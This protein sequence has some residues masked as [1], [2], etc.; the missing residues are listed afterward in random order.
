M[1]ELHEIV[2]SN[3]AII[4]EYLQHRDPNKDVKLQPCLNFDNKNITTTP[5]LKSD[6]VRFVNSSRDQLWPV[7][8]AIADVHPVM[9]SSYENIVP[10][11]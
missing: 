3:L 2:Q 9:R 7:W 6:G 8:L 5:V 11:A 4:E 10:T 1:S